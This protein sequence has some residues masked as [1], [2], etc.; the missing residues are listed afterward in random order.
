[1]LSAGFEP[2]ISAGERPHTY[3][4]DHVATRTGKE[5]RLQNDTMWI[6]E[7]QVN[8]WLSTTPQIYN[9]ECGDKWSTSYSYPLS[10]STFWIDYYRLEQKGITTFSQTS[11]IN[12]NCAVYAHYIAAVTEFWISHK[13]VMFTQLKIPCHGLCRQILFICC[14]SVSMTS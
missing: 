11:T 13:K 7:H 1:M 6:T 3:T 10:P 4:L 2:T 8:V 14:Y 12:T 5:H 9:H